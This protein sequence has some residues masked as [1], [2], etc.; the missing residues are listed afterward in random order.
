MISAIEQLRQNVVRVKSLGGL[1]LAL[2]ALTTPIVDASDLLRAQ[3]VLA[4]SAF[5]QYVH[6][7]T[8][9]GMLEIFDGGRAP[10]QAYR[11]FKVS[12][13]CFDFGAAPGL[14]RAALEA[15]IREQH[16]YLSFQKPEKVAN[17][18]RLI[19]EGPIWDDISTVLGMPTKDVKDRLE[20]VIG[21]RNK[22]AHEADLDPTYPNLR[23]PI[24]PSDIEDVVTF[25][26][27]VVESLHTV[28]H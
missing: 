13:E 12:L 21:R 16:S 6:E 15:D 11:R 23:W 10:T 7:V 27:R 20:L 8:R 5:D 26:E 22:I 1:Y 25:L 4:V 9:L 3:Y 24:T 18:I 19:Y 14:A 28:V 17:A 2:R